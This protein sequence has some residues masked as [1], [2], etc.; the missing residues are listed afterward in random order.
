MINTDKPD[1]AI[2]AHFTIK[3]IEALKPIFQ[4][5][6]V[7]DKTCATNTEY[8]VIIEAT[9]KIVHYVING[10][11]AHLQNMKTHDEQSAL[12][13]GLM[14]IDLTTCRFIRTAM[15]KSMINGCPIDQV[16]E[17]AKKLDEEIEVLELFLETYKNME[18]I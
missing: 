17:P 6:E 15:T 5:L 8:K 4:A 16:E 1:T 11:G 12:F 14:E 2:D 13:K 3:T 7:I 9:L 10:V 18:K